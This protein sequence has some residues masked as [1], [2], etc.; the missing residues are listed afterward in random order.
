MMSHVFTP[1][2]RRENGRPR[3]TQECWPHSTQ[4]H[5]S[6]ATALPSRNSFKGGSCRAPWPSQG[7]HR[8]TLY[9]GPGAGRPDPCAA[10]SAPGWRR[11]VSR[12]ALR[13]RSSCCLWSVLS[14]QYL[15]SSTAGRESGKSAEGHQ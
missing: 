15:R 10:A 12:A 2:A 1:T 6:R 5:P 4:L 14:R 7:L 9:T 11:R 3:S 13:D 8:P